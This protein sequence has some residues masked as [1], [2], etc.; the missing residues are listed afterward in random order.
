MVLGTVII[1]GDLMVKSFDRSSCR[2]SSNL[3]RLGFDRFKEIFVWLGSNG[4]GI[5]G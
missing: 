5:D 3:V 4:V 2:Y 1:L